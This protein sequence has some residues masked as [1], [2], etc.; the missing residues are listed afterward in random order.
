MKICMPKDFPLISFSCLLLCFFF[1][2]FHFGWNRIESFVCDMPCRWKK[3]KHKYV[4]QKHFTKQ[5]LEVEQGIY[6]AW[7][8]IVYRSTQPTIHITVRPF[9]IRSTASSFQLNLD[10]WLFFFFIYFQLTLRSKSGKIIIKD[11]CLPIPI[12]IGNAH[13]Y[14][15]FELVF[16]CVMIILCFVYVFTTQNHIT[17]FT[18]SWN[19]RFVCA[20]IREKFRA[21]QGK[22][23]HWRVYKTMC[24]CR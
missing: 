9:I 24:L 14:M 21:Y 12:Y 16:D 20:E 1:L 18:A 6:C 13:R 19:K 23:T 3:G 17:T 22:Q 8:I 5:H 4:L 11:L 10:M 2:F 7:Y 15:M